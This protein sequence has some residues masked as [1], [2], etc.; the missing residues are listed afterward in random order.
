MGADP[1]R[2]PWRGHGHG[3]RGHPGQR[4]PCRRGRG[5][6]R[7]SG[8]P[9][10]RRPK[11]DGHPSS[12]HGSAPASPRA[13]RPG[14][15]SAAMGTRAAAGQRTA[16]GPGVS[17]APGR[18][19]IAAQARADTPGT[20]VLGRAGRGRLAG[21]SPECGSASTGLATVGPERW[22]SR[23]QGQHGRSGDGRHA[24]R[25]AGA[26]PRPDA[27]P[28]RRS[29]TSAVGRRTP[30]QQAEAGYRGN[31]LPRGSVRASTS[32]RAH[33]PPGRR[34]G[35]SPGQQARQSHG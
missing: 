24:P 28:A 19:W 31:A 5:R 21:R 30:G 10:R 1:V 20:A 17:S 11:P 13:D 35:V 12:A 16:V 32:R 33:R 26:C 7:D 23:R 15:R 22:W 2:T 18:N 8:C 9:R 3:G 25:P 14:I 4:V 29:G 27:V 6:Q 34:F